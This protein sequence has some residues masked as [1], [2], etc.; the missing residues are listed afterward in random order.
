MPIFAIPI[1]ILIVLFAVTAGGDLIHSI[2]LPFPSF[3]LFPEQKGGDVASPPAQQTPS[4]IGQAPLGRSPPFILDTFITKGPNEGTLLKENNVVAFEFEGSVV[5][6]DTAGRITFETRVAGVDSDWKATS[7]RQR[8]VTLPAGKNEYVFEV[9][10]KIDKEIDA[11]PA[12]RT[13]SI[14][15]SPSFGK[16]TVGSFQR[17]TSSSPF[18]ISLQTKLSSQ[19]QANISGWTIKGS[20]GEYHIGKGIR[21][22]YPNAQNFNEDIMLQRGDRVLLSGAASPF[23]SGGNFKPN[24]CL[25]YLK[26]YYSFPLSISSSCPDKPSVEEISFLGPFCQD[27]ILKEISFGSCQIPDYSQNLRV[28]SDPTCASYLRDNF[29][30]EACF[31]KHAQEENFTKN[32]WHIY[33]AKDFARPLH[34]V[35]TLED[36]D[37]LL[38]DKYIY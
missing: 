17:T 28:A 30:Y 25:G 23:G 1:L 15:V 27:F 9:R 26:Q 35:I 22:L 36:Q 2:D 34:D 14:E 6:A 31:Q 10:S 4:I 13:F 20:G 37:G 18:L 8:T 12:T 24:V 5:P 11:T 3:R 38:V 29:T 7:S 16:V 21:L 32:E 19:E 33:A